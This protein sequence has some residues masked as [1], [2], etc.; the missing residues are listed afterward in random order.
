MTMKSKQKGEEKIGPLPGS[1]SQ[2]FWRCSSGRLHL[3]PNCSRCSALERNNRHYGVHDHVPYSE[4]SY[5]E[6]GVRSH[7]FR[8]IQLVEA[9]FLCFCNSDS[10]FL[11]IGCH[12]RRWF[13]GSLYVHWSDIFLFVYTDTDVRDYHCQSWVS[14]CDFR[15]LYV[16]RA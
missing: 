4:L 15:E 11:H 10:L 3:S 12:G 5:L 2:C 8:S 1:F 9:L 7:A 13:G 16:G 6:A 14:R